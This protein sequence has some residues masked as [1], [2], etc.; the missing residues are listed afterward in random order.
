MVVKMGESGGASS[1]TSLYASWRCRG[2]DKRVILYREL[3]LPW[4]DKGLEDG[5][6]VVWDNQANQLV[7]F[8]VDRANHVSAEMPS[9]IR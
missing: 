8:R 3:P 2:S 6:V 5:S 7:A 9:V 1:M 4:F